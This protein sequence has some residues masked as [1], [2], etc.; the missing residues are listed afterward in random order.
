MARLAFSGIFER[1]PDLRILCHHWGGY[2]PHADGRMDPHWQNGITITPDAEP[3][4]QDK[5]RSLRDTFKI[6]YGDPAM[7]GGQAAS[8][9][10]LAFFGAG[11]SA[12]ATDYPFD[13]EEGSFVIRETIGAIDALY[14]EPKP[15][16]PRT[17]SDAAVESTFVAT[18]EI[19]PKGR[20]HAR[21]AEDRLSPSSSTNWL[22]V[23]RHHTT[24]RAIGTGSPPRSSTRAAD[25]MLVSP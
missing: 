20:T 2:A 23:A 3:I 9:C 13:H 21:A 12:F 6:F 18:L 24:A 1:H 7:F 5:S 17:L 10:G 14:D 19:T 15:G 16:A 4:W 11:H 22:L 25:R 8:Q